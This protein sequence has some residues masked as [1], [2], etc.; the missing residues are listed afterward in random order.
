LRFDCLLKLTER[1]REVCYEQKN[2]SVSTFVG[3]YAFIFPMHRS[4]G[5]ERRAEDA[6]AD[7]MDHLEWVEESGFFQ[8]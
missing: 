4:Y 8:Y 7:F 3:D 2:L 6:L 5:Q 1:E